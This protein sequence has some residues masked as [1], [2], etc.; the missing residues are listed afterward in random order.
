MQ[1]SSGIRTNDPSVGASKDSSCLRP[2]VHRDR[3]DCRQS[4]C[5]EV[6]WTDNKT[7]I[8]QKFK[9]CYKAIK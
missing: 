3:L 7:R 5:F 2:R 4:P 6:M 8:N 1:A 9:K